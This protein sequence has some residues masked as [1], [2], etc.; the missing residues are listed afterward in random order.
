MYLLFYSKKVFFH[1]PTCG[2]IW[3]CI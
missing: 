1:K 2:W 3:V